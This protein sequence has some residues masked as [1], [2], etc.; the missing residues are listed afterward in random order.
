MMVVL[1]LM[2]HGDKADNANCYDC[3]NDDDDD[4]DEKCVNYKAM[5]NIIYFCC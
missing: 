2:M 4:D 5:I 1:M 3:D